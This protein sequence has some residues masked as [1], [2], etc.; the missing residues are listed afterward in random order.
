MSRVPAGWADADPQFDEVGFDLSAAMLAPAFEGEPPKK[1]TPRQQERLTSVLRTV[2]RLTNK[3]GYEAVKM[4]DTVEAGI[5][6]GTIYRFFGSRDFLVFRATSAWFEWAAVRSLP[7]GGTKDFRR[8]SMYQFER[9][10]AQWAAH[11]RVVEAWLRSATS[12]DPLVQ[13][14]QRT[15]RPSLFA[16]HQWAPMDDLDPEYAA[17]LRTMIEAHAFGGMVR[18]VHGQRTLAELKT[19]FANLLDL[20]FD[21]PLYRAAD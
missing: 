21:P 17:K 18:W 5:A 11:P 1:L 20:V 9:L 14:L 15:Y 8:R 12:D 4:R 6:L 16:A 7:R 19:D 2:L 13:E 3:G 10:T